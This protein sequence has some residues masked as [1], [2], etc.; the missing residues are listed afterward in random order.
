MRS[1]AVS[2]KHKI[3]P[4]KTRERE[5]ANHPLGGDRHLIV[6]YRAQYRRMPVDFAFLTTSKW[7]LAITAPFQQAIALVASCPG[8]NAWAFTL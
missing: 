7:R 2:L 1:S 4:M 6:H 8:A 5:S 3:K